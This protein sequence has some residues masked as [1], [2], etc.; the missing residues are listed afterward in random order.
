MFSN[1]GGWGMM[2]WGLGGYGGLCI[3][4]FV[5]I[6]AIVVFAFRGRKS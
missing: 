2:G 1:T 3:L 5:A 6:V 4:I